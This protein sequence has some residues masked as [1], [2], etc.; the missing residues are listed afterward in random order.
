[1]VF[2]MYQFLSSMSDLYV[3]DQKAVL[4]LEELINNHTYPYTDL[5]YGEYFE[6]SEKYADWLEDIRLEE[7][8]EA[9]EYLDYLEHAPTY[10]GGLTIW[11]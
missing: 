8:R 6:T 10:Y 4:Y 1:M 5:S 7:R 9:I 3:L 11:M 2:K